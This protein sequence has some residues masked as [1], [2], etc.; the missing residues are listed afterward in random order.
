[1]VERVSVDGTGPAAVSAFVVQVGYQVFEVDV[2]RRW[3]V[4]RGA[5]SQRTIV[6]G[7]FKKCEFVVF[8]TFYWVSDTY[9]PAHIPDDRSRVGSFPIGEKTNPFNNR[10]LRS[11]YG[12]GSGEYDDLASEDASCQG[13]VH[14][15]R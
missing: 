2:T 10:V 3:A 14:R 15:E 7:L 12:P 13:L 1:M 11:E 6:G 4:V 9:I 5:E 8:S